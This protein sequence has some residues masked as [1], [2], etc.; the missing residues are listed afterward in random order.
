MRLY[1]LVALW[2]ALVGFA[3]AIPAP[4][5]SHFKPKS[6][7]SGPTEPGTFE[8]FQAAAAER[9]LLLLKNHLGREGIFQLLKPD[10]E[11]SNAF[12]HSALAKSPPGAW[13]PSTARVIVKGP[14]LTAAS[15]AAWFGGDTGDADKLLRAEPEHYFEAVTADPVTGALVADILEAWGGRLT[16]FKIPEYGAPDRVAYPFLPALPD[17]PQQFSG[18]GTL[19]DGSGAVFMVVHNSWKDTA[20]GKG[21]EA[22]LSVWL[23]GATPVEVVEALRQHQAVEFTNWLSNAQSDIASG[24]FKAP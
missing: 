4:R 18:G 15:F 5:G 10:I 14:G 9:A 23:P 8:T 21:V 1:R 20:D 2:Y 17:F 7:I 24:K 19:Q 22:I 12:W 16:Y 3:S 13:V 6:I 11:E